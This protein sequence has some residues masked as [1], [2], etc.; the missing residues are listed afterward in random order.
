MSFQ[1]ASPRTQPRAPRPF[2]VCIR[3]TATG[4]RFTASD[5]NLSSLLSHAY[6]RLFTPSPFGEGLSASFSYPYKRLGPQLLSFDTHTNARRCIGQLAS[7]PQLLLTLSLSFTLFAKSEKYLLCLQWV[8]H[9]LRKTTGVYPKRFFT[10]RPFPR[11]ANPGIAPSFLLTFRLRY[12]RRVASRSLLPWT[13][14]SLR[15]TPPLPI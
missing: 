14:A 3:Q 13:S 11:G 5:A 10:P 12:T 6:K 1:P 7:L 8:P 4:E 2:F 15:P 9:S